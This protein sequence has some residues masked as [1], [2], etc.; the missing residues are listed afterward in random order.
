MKRESEDTAM[1][2]QK[3]TWT[4]RRGKGKDRSGRLVP[5]RK[6]TVCV[7]DRVHHLLLSEK[8][9]KNYGNLS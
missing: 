3:R 4:Q 8:T 6:R 2:G 1:N 5:N 7:L 9:Q